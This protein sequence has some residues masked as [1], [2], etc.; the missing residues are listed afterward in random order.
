MTGKWAGKMLVTSPASATSTPPLRAPGLTISIS[1]SQLV[2]RQK[3]VYVSTPKTTPDRFQRVHCYCCPH[4]PRIQ[5]LPL[6]GTRLHH[7]LLW[8]VVNVSAPCLINCTQ[9][10]SIAPHYQHLCL[11]DCIPLQVSQKYT[12]EGAVL[13]VLKD[14]QEVEVH[15]TLQ[16]IWRFEGMEQV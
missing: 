8:A 11:V 1:V 13:R 2:M 15:V 12:N 4:S 16:V 6:S 7:A 5:D 10:K 14:G 3:G 9:G